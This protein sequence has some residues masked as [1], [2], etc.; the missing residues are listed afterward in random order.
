MCISEPGMTTYP[1]IYTMPEFIVVYLFLRQHCDA[2]NIE[3]IIR[4]Q[5]NQQLHLFIYL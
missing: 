2:F 4:V 1:V 3:S 5:S